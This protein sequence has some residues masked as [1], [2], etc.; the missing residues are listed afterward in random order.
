M[1]TISIERL[2]PVCTPVIS[3]LGHGREPLAGLRAATA[4][5]DDFLQ[6]RPSIPDRRT[7]RYFFE[8]FLGGIAKAAMGSSH[9]RSKE[10]Y[11]FPI[12]TRD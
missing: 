5:L 10:A 6:S 2:K 4:I 12:L 9:I 3:D 1:Q 11:I 7:S 8:E